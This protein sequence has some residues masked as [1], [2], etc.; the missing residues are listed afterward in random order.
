MTAS[1]SG[2][3]RLRG[4]LPEGTSVA[5]KAGTSGYENRMAA[6]TNDVGLVTLPDGRR[7]ALAVLVTDAHANQ[8]SV[9]HA[10]AAITRAE[11]GHPDQWVFGR[12]PYRYPI[13]DLAKSHVAQFLLTTTEADR[14]R[15]HD[16]EAVGLIVGWF[17]T[18]AP[19]AGT[20]ALPDRLFGVKADITKQ[21]TDV[22]VDPADPPKPTSMNT[23]SLSQHQ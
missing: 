10:M 19:P 7:L 12:N 2:P 17:D 9:E 22:S 6:A 18:A 15:Q 16:Y 3:K 5:H 8:T 1:P 11:H 20:S 23:D 4:L 13:T 14:Y 21:P